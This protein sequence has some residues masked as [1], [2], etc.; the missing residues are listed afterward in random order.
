MLLNLYRVE[1]KF[2]PYYEI[3]NGPYTSA[4]DVTPGMAKV[5]EEI[6]LEKKMLAKKFG[7]NIFSLQETL[8]KFYG[9]TG[10]N[11]YET[12][13]NCYAYKNQ[14]APL[15]ITS[16]YVTEDLQFAFVPFLNIANQI[17]EDLPV[18]K[19]MVEIGKIATG[20]NFW[21]SG[22][23]LEDLGLQGKSINE[24]QEYLATG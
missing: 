8:Y 21:E 20:I 15:S 17:G 10:D 22:L 12:I 3:L 5:M 18:T 14:V 6:D 7:L 9:A 1:R 11:L 24:I 19:G 16:R 13:S 23:K 4:Y 2:Y